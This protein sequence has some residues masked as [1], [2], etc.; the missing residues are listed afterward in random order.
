MVMFLIPIVFVGYSIWKNRK[1]KDSASIC[2]NGVDESDDSSNKG[3]LLVVSLRSEDSSMVNSNQSTCDDD[4]SS[5]LSSVTSTSL[6]SSSIQL[7]HSTTTSVDETS[8][9]MNAMWKQFLIWYFLIRGGDA[10]DEDKT[11]MKKP[12]TCEVRR[13]LQEQH[14]SRTWDYNSISN[15]Y[16]TQNFFQISSR[17]EA[18]VYGLLTAQGSSKCMH[19]R[20]C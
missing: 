12:T 18:L 16:E 13:Y 10:E 9:I 15:K 14:S 6:S 11:D 3:P 8:S 17:R 20:F 1:L 2:S 19:A 7:L 5:D 4:T